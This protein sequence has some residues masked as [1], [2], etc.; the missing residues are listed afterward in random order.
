[1]VNTINVA[2]RVAV[3]KYSA[4]SCSAQF[5]GDRYSSAARVCHVAPAT[6][7]MTDCVAT[8]RTSTM[9]GCWCAPS[10]DIS[11][12]IN[13]WTVKSDQIG[14]V[15]TVYIDSHCDRYFSVLHVWKKIKNLSIMWPPFCVYC[16]SPS[17]P[18]TRRGCAPIKFVVNRSLWDQLAEPIRDQLTV[19]PT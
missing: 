2:G 17:S 4:E 9:S 11:Y 16:H 12:E 8:S 3:I 7:C 19:G 14:V 10:G 6:I 15:S 13:V 18:L 1:M 5:H